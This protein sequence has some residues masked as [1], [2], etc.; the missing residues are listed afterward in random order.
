MSSSSPR[1]IIQRL[2]TTASST[3]T[4]T[5][6][7]HALFTS[8]SVSSSSI[9]H[10]HP[11]RLALPSINNVPRYVLL[12][13]GPGLSEATGARVILNEPLAG[14]TVSQRP[15]ATTTHTHTKHASISSITPSINSAPPP[16]KAEIERKLSVKL[17]GVNIPRRP[18]KVRSVW[19][20]TRL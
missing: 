2:T 4:S 15:P 12:K 1:V 5:S 3:H 16:S 9:F 11:K 19:I 14:A 17:S 13:F 8:C 6:S 18:T 20:S 10:T 7:T